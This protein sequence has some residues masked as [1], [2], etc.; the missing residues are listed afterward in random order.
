M[1]QMNVTRI[2][3]LNVKCFP[4][5][6]RASFLSKEFNGLYIDYRLNFNRT[7]SPSSIHEEEGE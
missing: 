1:M 3:L 6:L 5:Q 4:K 2:T 7:Y